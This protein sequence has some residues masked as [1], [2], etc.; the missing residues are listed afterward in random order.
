MSN[1]KIL[2]GGLMVVSILIYHILFSPN[3]EKINA[4]IE[5]INTLEEIIN[6]TDEIQKLIDEAST[7]Y[8]SIDRDVTNSV[9][10][11]IPR[12]TPESFI[13]THRLV[14]YIGSLSQVGVLEGISLSRGADG[15][16]GVGL[17]TYKLSF[18]VENVNYSALKDILNKIEGWSRVVN[19]TS[20]RVDGGRDGKVSSSVDLDLI[21]SN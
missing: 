20:V 15:E 16:S 12:L 5:Y 2:I 13:Q 14:E 8:N 4:N 6:N 7:T 18:S 10:S 19:I 1:S 3:Y 17:I 11:A 21:F 9:D